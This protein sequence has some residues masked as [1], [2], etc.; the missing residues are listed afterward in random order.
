MSEHMWQTLVSMLSAVPPICQ[1]TRG[2]HWCQCYLLSLLYVRTH[3]ANIGVNVICCPSYMSE[4]M[5]QTLVSM[6]SAV[7]PIC[8][9]TRGKH[10]CQCYLLSLLYV[11]THVAN[12]GVNVI[13]YPSYMSEHTWQTLVSMLSAVSPIC[14]NTCSKHWCQCY[15]LSL[16]YVRTHVANIGVNVICCPS[17]MSEHT[18]Q[19]LV[20]MLSAVPPICQNTCG[21][22]WCQCYLLSLLY[23]RTHVANIGVNVICCPSYMSEHMWQTLV[24]MLSAVPPICQNTRG[25]HWC[26]C[27]LLSLLYVRT[28]VANIGVNVICCPSYMSEHM[29]QTLVSMLSAVPPICQNT[30]GKHWCQCYLLSLVYVRTHVANIGVNVI[31]CPSYM[32]EHM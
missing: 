13:C 14:Q 17:Y 15:L 31:C 1:N 27:Y 3:V 28:H 22:H 6:L 9:N 29:W 10:W 21:K 7:P 2:K 5:W 23:V 30:C 26:Q 32:S 25:K 12:I 24:S 18:W 19:T 11:R 4:H 16:V 20:S 8:Q